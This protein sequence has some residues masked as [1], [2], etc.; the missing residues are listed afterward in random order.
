[1]K[2]TEYTTIYTV[3]LTVPLPF[4]VMKMFQGYRGRDDDTSRLP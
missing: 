1:M 3:D 2:Y 4:T